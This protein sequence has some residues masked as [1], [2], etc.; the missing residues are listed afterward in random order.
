VNSNHGYYNKYKPV[1]HQRPISN[2][3][4]EAGVIPRKEIVSNHGYYNRLKTIF[5]GHCFHCKNFGHQARHCMARKSETPKLKDQIIKPY[6]PKR[7]GQIK[8]FNSFDPLTKFDLICLLCYNNGHYE[9]HCPLKRRKASSE[10]PNMDECGL[11][12]YAQNN[13]NR[14]F[15]DSGCSRH[16]TG[17]KRKFVSLSKKEG[18]VSFG[19]GSGRIAGK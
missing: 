2:P 5:L 9:Q 4:N 19:S 18:N 14:W 8:T 17:D 15:V 1:F 3:K 13:E 6:G 12:L 11:A 10:N 7:Q 16:M